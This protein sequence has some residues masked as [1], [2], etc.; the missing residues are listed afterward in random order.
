ME[1]FKC[2]PKQG[3]RPSGISQEL[4]VPVLGCVDKTPPGER[5]SVKAKEGR[6]GSWKVAATST[7]EGEGKVATTSDQRRRGE[8][9]VA[10]WGW[11]REGG[12]SKVGGEREGSCSG[13]GGGKEGRV[14]GVRGEGKPVG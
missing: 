6:L 13:V 11:E 10:M 3:S 14:S 4:G 12:V 9:A 7:R 2:T 5:E 1:D 8:A